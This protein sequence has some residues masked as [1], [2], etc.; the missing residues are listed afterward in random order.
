ME[1][2]ILLLILTL[3][4]IAVY[5]WTFNVLWFK[6]DVL[7]EYVTV[8]PNKHLRSLNS[9]W[10]KPQNVSN[11]NSFM[12]NFYAE[13]SV[14]S[15]TMSTLMRMLF[16][17][18]MVCYTVTIEIV[19]WQIKTVD[20]DQQ[21]GPIIRFIWPSMAWSLSIILLLIQPFFIIIS[22]L[23]KFFKDSFDIDR[24]V[25]ATTALLATFII[26]LTLLDIGPF[27]YSRNI[28]TRLS[29]GG[30]ALMGV[31][32]GI[33]C[34]ST[35][36][37]TFLF[38]WDKY[39]EQSRSG[40]ALNRSSNSFQKDKFLIWASRTILKQK[41]E[42]YENR[43]QS[44]VN[45]LDKKEQGSPPEN[46]TKCLEMIGRY[47]LNLSKIQTAL[48]RPQFI[49][50]ARRIIEGGFF[51]YCFY[52]MAFTLLVRIPK[53]IKHFVK[54]PGDYEYEYF[55]NRSDP[56]AVTI[57]NILDIL[58]FHFNY[59]HDLDSLT[60]QISLF[61][62]AS[63]FMCS[64]SAVNTTIMFISGLLPVKFQLVAMFGL[65]DNENELPSFH[66]EKTKKKP[67]MIKNLLVSE[68]TGIYVVATILMIRSNLPFDVSV[69][70]KTLL[71]EKFTVPNLAIDC[72]FDEIFIVSCMLTIS[73]IKLAERTLFI[74]KRNN[75]EYT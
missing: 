16:S 1:E 29:V 55:Q 54:F 4:A 47:Q 72:W 52:K 73:F 11:S 22:L 38:F 31:L 20:M 53:I 14:S 71:G 30:V 62:S 3:S 66:N 18:A 58:L 13:Y 34:V 57:A 65:D 69:K 75:S 61:L 67:S 21:A 12:Q 27:V 36:Y 70:L 68:L 49:I 40:L 45:A 2:L 33:A 50:N 51:I 74:P 37:Y 5:D 10:D 24:L 32:S 17:A 48:K 28:L 44:M 41:A 39:I 7:F 46:R 19:L 60:N 59:Q 15:K 42:D 26:I 23:N 35:V 8:S 6:V 25:I 9:K 43:I 56:L 64:L 63:L